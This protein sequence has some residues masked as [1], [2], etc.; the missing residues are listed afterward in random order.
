M[1]TS[2]VRLLISVFAV[3]LWVAVTMG[4]ALLQVAEGTSLGQ[5]VSQQIV[6]GP[7]AAAALLLVIMYRP[8]A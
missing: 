4:L 7:P 1:G 2:S 8:G 5:L 3:V 6:W